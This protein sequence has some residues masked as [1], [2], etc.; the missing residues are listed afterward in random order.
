MVLSPAHIRNLHHQKQESISV[1]KLSQVRFTSL[2]MSA[3]GAKMGC[4]VSETASKLWPFVDN[5]QFKHFSVIQMTH[6][7]PLTVER[8]WHLLTVVLLITDQCQLRLLTQG[9][10]TECQKCCFKVSHPLHICERLKE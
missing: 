4:G 2:Q 5:T 10:Q 3:P 7:L 9:I 6:E 8:S 1:P